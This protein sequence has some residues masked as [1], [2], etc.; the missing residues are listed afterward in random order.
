[1]ICQMSY[2]CII[3]LQINVHNVANMDDGIL[4]PDP[5][6]VEFVNQNACMMH[7]L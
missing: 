4:V 6:L 7:L 3:L 2:P 5:E 1:M